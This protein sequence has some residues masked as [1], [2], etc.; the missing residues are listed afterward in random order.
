MSF[1]IPRIFSLSHKPTLSHIKKLIQD[2]SFQ[3]PILSQHRAMLPITIRPAA[4]FFRRG[5]MRIALSARNSVFAALTS[6]GGEDGHV[7]SRR[8][9]QKSVC[10]QGRAARATAA[11]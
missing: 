10:S 3:D 7:T 11:G 1:P 5:W 8:E 9:W 4:E 6:G 2:K